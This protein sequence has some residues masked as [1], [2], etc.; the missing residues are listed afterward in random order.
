LNGDEIGELAHHLGMPEAEFRERYTFRDEL[1]WTQLEGV[2][3]RCVFLD[4]V[5][6]L[7]RVYAAR[8]AQCRTF[9]F[10]RNAICDGDWTPEVREMC[11]G[12]GRGPGHTLE[13][14]QARMLEMDE[15][16]ED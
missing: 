1:G 11:E 5:T 15:S 16:P 13:Y 3:D 6:N 2:R 9:P 8:P 10:W 7:C 14:A 4:P 12:I